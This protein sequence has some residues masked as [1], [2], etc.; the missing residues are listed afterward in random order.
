M[1]LEKYIFSVFV[2]LFLPGLLLNL[3]LFR[4][5]RFNLFETVAY[6]FG[7]S[8]A[9]ISIISIVSFISHASI[10]ISF[11]MLVSISVLS[12]VFIFRKT[13]NPSVPA[14][15][16]G[17]PAIDT[18]SATMPKRKSKKN[19]SLRGAH[20]KDAGNLGSITREASF[21]SERILGIKERA[22]LILAVPA[23]LSLTAIIVMG[24]SIEMPPLA[25]VEDKN[26]LMIA[27]KILSLSSLRIDSLLYKPGET[28]PYVISIYSYILALLSYVSGIE[29]IQIYCK[30]RFIFSL[31]SITTAYSI[32]RVLF[33]KIYE[34][35]WILILLISSVLISGWG[36][37]YSS[38]SFGQFFP[39]SHYQDLSICVILPV[40]LLFF[41]RGLKEG[42]SF[43]FISMVSTASLFFIHLRELMALL[44]L[45]TSILAGF[46]IFERDRKI[47]LRG[48]AVVGGIVLIGIVVKIIQTHYLD[49]RILEYNKNFNVYVNEKLHNLINYSDPLSLFYPP[50]EGD[51]QLLSSYSM[52]YQN[53]YYLFPVF[54]LPFL[55]YLRKHTGFLIL[56]FSVL[57][58][59][60]IP[61][62]PILSL[63]T[64]KFTYSQILYGAPVTLGLF[65]FSYIIVAL[66][67]WCFLLFISR[68]SV[69]LKRF[70]AIFF[71]VF[72]FVT[73]A[74]I[75]LPQGFYH[76]AP[77]FFYIW[78]FMGTYSISKIFREHAE[79]YIFN[80]S[81]LLEKKNYIL[82]PFLIIF[83][84]GAAF[85]RTEFFGIKLIPNFEKKATSSGIGLS[86]FIDAYSNSKKTVSVADW[87][88]W[89]RQS[90]FKDI[91]LD[92][93][94]FMRND[95]PEGRIFAAPF[96]PGVETLLNLP[97]MT[98]QYAYS[99][100]TYTTMYENEFLEAL[101][102]MRFN[103]SSIALARDEKFRHD[104]LKEKYE[105]LLKEN[106]VIQY[107]FTL[108]YL[109][110]DV[111]SKYQPIYNTF[112][113]PEITLNMIKI[114][115]VEYIYVTPEWH[116]HLDN[117]FSS[118]RGHIEKVYDKD[119]YSIYK[120]RP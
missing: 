82:L 43:I 118:L 35:P 114:F 106:D 93:V 110:D 67:L 83:L 62:I 17:H 21:F 37:N 69:Y 79:R 94:N 25:G 68:Y 112:D 10:K 57:G 23:L 56:S 18:K 40:S 39:F 19:K 32:T 116:S 6:S 24:Y 26:V 76:V 16:K 50:L 117:V 120:V 59:T 92:V 88:D 12:A 45:Y 107:Y 80:E 89:Y 109:F 41:I 61:T 20:K 1:F 51:I 66:S 100:G 60:L 65:P 73:I 87:E 7:S 4:D 27:Q 85:T 63:L 36:Y 52:L 95:I 38:G 86:P 96:K 104:Y 33:P 64:I 8:L 54:L 30:I 91:P 72:F 70:F 101:Y 103:K 48:V 53:P 119:S 113:S 13:K 29:V 2:I 44:F 47:I 71:V 34:L 115:K 31:I 58:L 98:N 49:P 9:L 105:A 77:G 3:V 81:S 90:V 55:F 15:N 78:I 108:I 102:R 111:M 28:Y 42:W 14:E 5:K 99:S 74:L 22:E 84:I 75:R 11:L 97:A 46:F